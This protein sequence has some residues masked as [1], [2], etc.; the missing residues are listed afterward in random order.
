MRHCS[1]VGSACASGPY[2]GWD[3]RH[4]EMFSVRVMEWFGSEGTLKLM[5]LQLPCRGQGHLQS[6]LKI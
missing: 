3:F 5:K 1:G 4:V 2:N 6:G